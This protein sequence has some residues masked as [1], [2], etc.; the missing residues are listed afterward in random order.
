MLKS[1]NLVKH[2][3]LCPTPD[4]ELVH[5]F[6]LFGEV[7]VDWAVGDDVRPAIGELGFS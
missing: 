6:F 2:T 5:T 7:E 1:I 3:N 4:V